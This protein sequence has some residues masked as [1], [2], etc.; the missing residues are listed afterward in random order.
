MLELST[1]RTNT[2]HSSI[3]PTLVTPGAAKFWITILVT[4]VGALTGL[5]PAAN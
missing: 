1:D 2:D 3:P 4:G 5:G